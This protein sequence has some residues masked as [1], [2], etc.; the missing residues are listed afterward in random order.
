[1]SA[2]GTDFY[3][4]IWTVLLMLGTITF[5]CW[6]APIPEGPMFIN[7]VG[8]GGL[9]IS[10]LTLLGSLV[11]PIIPSPSDRTLT[12]RQ[13]LLMNPKYKVFES[14]L[15]HYDKDVRGYKVVH[16]AADNIDEAKELVIQWYCQE[17]FRLRSIKKVNKEVVI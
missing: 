11:P 5:L 6:V 8:Y 2:N 4:V 16:V 7:R 9:I 10:I 17:G 15:K 14:K 13:S 12:A 1:M 3:N